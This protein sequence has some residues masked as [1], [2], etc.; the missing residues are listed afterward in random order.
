LT[1]FLFSLLN[2]RNTV[3]AHFKSK[4]RAETVRKGQEANLKCEAE[5]DRPLTITWFRDKVPFNPRESPNGKYDITETQTPT[6]F[7]SEIVIRST[8]RR[9]SSLFT[10]RASNA[11]G[12]DETNIQVIMQG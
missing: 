11:Y 3:S 8:D 1:P 12:E 9:D 5:G 6:G 7:T 4:F 2:A 10:C